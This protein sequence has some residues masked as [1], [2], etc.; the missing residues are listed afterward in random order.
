M[1]LRGRAGGL[2]VEPRSRFERFARGPPGKTETCIGL[3]AS[4]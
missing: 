1:T 3:V 2:M 4:F